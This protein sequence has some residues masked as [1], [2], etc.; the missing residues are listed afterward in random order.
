MTVGC[1]CEL[2]GILAVLL[3]AAIGCSGGSSGARPKKPPYQLP[4]DPVE[5]LVLSPKGDLLVAACNQRLRFWDPAGA[6]ELRNLAAHGSRITS[7]AMSADGRRIV[8]GCY[9]RS[10]KVWDAG[11]GK[12]L[13]TLPGHRAPVT[14]LAFS[15][16]A[17]RLASGAGD[18]NP[19]LGR[20]NAPATDNVR[21]ELKLWDLE[22]QKPL[23]DLK[24]H[25]SP[26][27]GLAFRGDG[28][29]LISCGL[30]GQ[31]KL[32]N[33]NDRKAVRS[34]EGRQPPAKGLALSPDGRTLALAC[35]NQT[36]RLWDLD[37]WKEK[38]VLN[39]HA[40]R[41]N[42]V[43]FSPSGDL[44][45]SASDDETLIVWDLASGKPKSTLKGHTHYVQAVVFGPGNRVISG[46][47]DAEVRLWEV[48]KDKSLRTLE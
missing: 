26:I 48:G 39:G 27:S 11:T 43:A 47:I 13:F 12:E 30:D 36:I 6:R 7:M 23:A 25:G 9:D 44:L 35:H 18:P 42:A 31:V 41:V 45:A 46:G 32:W 16:D 2:R 3:T 5:A 1:T 24:G 19:F 33:L 21:T 40:D 10:I 29:T 22:A 4:P 15:P 34:I 17:K 38:G 20:D 14:A 28:E 8:T 37:S